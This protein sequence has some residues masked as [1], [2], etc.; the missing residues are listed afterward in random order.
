MQTFTRDTANTPVNEIPESN[1][2]DAFIYQGGRRY[3]S[4]K[5]HAK[6]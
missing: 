4:E 2:D 5:V 1:L 6:S 3:N